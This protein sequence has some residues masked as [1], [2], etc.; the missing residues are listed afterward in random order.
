MKSVEMKSFKVVQSTYLCPGAV[1]RLADLFP[2]ANHGPTLS[3]TLRANGERAKG[4]SSDQR[5]ELR[6]G[7]SPNLQTPLQRPPGRHDLDANIERDCRAQSRRSLAPPSRPGQSTRPPNKKVHQKAHSPS[8]AP[9]QVALA[10][11]ARIPTTRW[12][13]RGRRRRHSALPWPSADRRPTDWQR[14]DR[15]KR[16]GCFT[17]TA[18]A[19]SMAASA[20]PQ[21]VAM[22]ASRHSER[23]RPSSASWPKPQSRSHAPPPLGRPSHGTHTCCRWLR[24]DASSTATWST[25][26][27][28]PRTTR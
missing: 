7:T 16:A 28:S 4:A 12:V 21:W 6:L 18:M 13:S 15:A 23:P 14:R 20:I 27:K 1:R 24:V 11:A 19:C 26:L 5:Q 22:I 9:A 17:K 3:P 10:D 8:W 25:S 2:S